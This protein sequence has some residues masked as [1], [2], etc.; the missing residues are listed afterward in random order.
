MWLLMEWI[1]PLITIWTLSDIW[2]RKEE[3]LSC[4]CHGYD[5]REI[6]LKILD[7]EVE[8]EI[9]SQSWRHKIRENPAVCSGEVSKSFSKTTQYPNT[10]WQVFSQV[11]K[12]S[13]NSDCT[14]HFPCEELTILKS[15]NMWELISTTGTSH[16][17]ILVDI[18]A[19]SWWFASWQK[20]AYIL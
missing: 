3:E 17:V 4:R 9:R 8:D 10:I 13:Q 5:K 19:S 20:L 16:Q 7:R 15:I 11:G 18:L 12:L 6:A 1:L 2:R 14:E